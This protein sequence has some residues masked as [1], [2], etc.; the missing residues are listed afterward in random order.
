MKVSNLISVVFAVVLIWTSTFAG[1]DEGQLPDSSSVPLVSQTRCPVMGGK[2]DSAQYTDIQGQRVYHCCGGCSA[3]LIA[4][5]DKYFQKAAS[6]GVLFENIQ[7]ACPVSGKPID[8]TVFVDYQGR[9]VYFNSQKSA[10]KFL[11]NSAKYL[12]KLDDQSHPK[13]KQDHS[14]NHDGDHSGHSHGG[15]CGM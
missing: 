6:E 10:E 1:N 12:A 7:T 5:P 15:G 11:K 2:I 9:R 8:K 4:N 13:E 14:Q 3:K